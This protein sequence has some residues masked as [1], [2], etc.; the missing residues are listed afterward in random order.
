VTNDDAW[1]WVS[2]REIRDAILAGEVSALDVTEAALSRIASRDAEI[3]AFLTVMGDEALRT[4][5]ELD[6][7]LAAGGTPGPLHGVPI[8]LKDEVWTKDVRST[9]GSK[10]YEDFIPEE[11]S[12]VVRRLREAGA[13]IVGKTQLPEFAS[14]PRSKNFVGE[15]ARNPFDPT[16]ISGAS[17]SGSAASV[18]AGMVPLSLGS[19]GGGSIRIPSSLNGTVGLFPTPGLVS[20]R[21]S[22]SYSPYGSLGPIGRSVTDVALMLQVV[23]GNDPSNPS[24]LPGSAP[25]YL[26]DLE[27]GV[28]GL[29]I[30]FTPDFGWIDVDP[31][32][33]ALTKE[34]VLQLGDAGADVHF[35]S[36][37]IEDIWHAFMAVTRGAVEFGGEHPVFTS[38]LPH[39]IRVM[40]HFGDLIPPLQA[41]ALEAGPLSREEYEEGF[42]VIERVRAQMDELLSTYDVICSPTMACI[43]PRIPDEWEMPYSDER[44]GTNFTSL[45]NVCRQAALSYPV[46]LV[47]GMPVGLQ[48]IGPS[49]SEGLVLR[50]ARALEQQR[51]F[52]HHPERLS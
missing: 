25:D 2:A 30:A 29:K 21:A 34:A 14:W 41:A 1:G 6:A 36:L 24:S 40:E 15:E 13:V 9:F 27:R 18:A 32:I 42:E 43:A 35:P 23:A 12:E 49:R 22:F 19:D 11:D 44:M 51:P 50:V 37:S 8:S 33:A 28:E 7:H 17:S 5:A 20:D 4:A 3:H 16:R 39:M 45:S 46:G 38:S 10:I 48:I 47:E 52:L 31:H 26:V